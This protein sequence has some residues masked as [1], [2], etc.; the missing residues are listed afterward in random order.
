M[1]RGYLMGRSLASP[2]VDDP[3]AGSPIHAL[4]TWTL[5][6]KVLVRCVTTVPEPHHRGSIA[7]PRVVLRHLW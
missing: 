3:N 2:V 6:E 1:R 5:V 7:G 4:H